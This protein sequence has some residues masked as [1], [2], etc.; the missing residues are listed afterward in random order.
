M[1]FICSW[2]CHCV[3]RTWTFLIQVTIWT[4]LEAWQEKRT[5]TL[6]LII[7]RT[8]N[9]FCRAL[10]FGWKIQDWMSF[11]EKMPC[12]CGW[13]GEVILQN[14]FVSIEINDTIVILSSQGV[15]HWFRH[16]QCDESFR[17]WTNFDSTT[18]KKFH[19]KQHA[20]FSQITEIW[21]HFHATCPKFNMVTARSVSH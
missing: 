17:F 15:K 18:H 5:Q 7:S 11:G 21:S 16:G 13:T 12:I 19:K 10:M 8:W 6:S 20:T 2:T 3:S 4:R 14:S 9:L 1:I